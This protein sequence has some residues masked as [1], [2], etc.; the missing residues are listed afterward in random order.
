MT[1]ATKQVD[2]GAG[3][4]AGGSSPW[5]R[6]QTVTKVADGFWFVDTAG[7]GG[8]KLS[9]Q[10]Q[11][12]MPDYLRCENGW[13]EEDCDWAIPFVFYA[14]ELLPI[15]AKSC[16]LAVKIFIDWRPDQYERYSGATIKPGASYVKDQRAFAAAN[17]DNLIA[18]AAWGDWHTKVPAGSVGVLAGRGGRGKN[19]QYPAE[20]SY[21]LVPAAEY[22]ARNHFGFVI[23][24]ARHQSWA[25]PDLQFQRVI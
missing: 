17:A 4:R 22:D 16:A 10:R 12:A 1:T 6:I 8:L 18:M 20:T 23:D 13:Y 19:G 3:P 2:H 11:A 5:G 7:H 24:P 15:D 21:W 9:R 25:G 14:R